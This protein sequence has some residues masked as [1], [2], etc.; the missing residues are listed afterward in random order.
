MGFYF[1]SWD[2]LILIASAIKLE[3][4]PYLQEQ[5][6]LPWSNKIC[7]ASSIVITIN[8]FFMKIFDKILTFNYYYV[9]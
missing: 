6:L 4:L 1:L 8:I 2:S 5:V 9:V 3:I 7:L